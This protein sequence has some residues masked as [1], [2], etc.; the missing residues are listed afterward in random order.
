MP[1]HV[2]PLGNHKV[3]TIATPRAVGHA[4]RASVK[5]QDFPDLRWHALRYEAIS[6]LF[7]NTDLRDHE[8]M[9]ITGHLSPEML[10]RY[11][12]LGSHRLALRL[13]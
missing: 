5:D 2:V 10:K 3:L 4:F 1:V 12:H 7:E 6:R 9:A 8:I 11:S 13:G